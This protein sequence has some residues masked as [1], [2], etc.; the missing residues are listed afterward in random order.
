MSKEKNGFVSRWPIKKC[1]G[2]QVVSD[3]K[4]RKAKREMQKLLQGILH[5]GPGKQGDIR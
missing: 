3:K 2:W 5:S 1:R 4:E